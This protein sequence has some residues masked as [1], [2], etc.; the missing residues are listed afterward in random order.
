L[1]TA[2]IKLDPF[3]DRLLRWWDEHGRQDLPWQ[4]PRTPY[5]VWVSEI[6]LQQT[7]VATVIPYFERWMKRFPDLRTLAEAPLDDVLAHW[8]GL[9]Y[10]ARARNLHRAAAQCLEQHTGELPLNAEALSALPGIGL[11]TANAIISQST[12]R[13]AAVL[14]GN[15]RRSLARHL[16]LDGWTG[17]AAVQKTLW[18]EAEARLPEQRGADYT[19]AIM[20]L[21]AMVCTRSNPDCP[22]CPVSRDCR[23][24]NTGQV[25]KYPT[26]RPAIKVTRKSFCMLIIRDGQGRVLLVKRPPSGIWGGL[27]SLPMGETVGNIETELGLSD[28]RTRPLET[29]NHRLSHIHMSIHAAMATSIGA[30]HVKCSS[31]QSWLDPADHTSIGLPKPVSELLTRIKDG[32]IQ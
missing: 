2:E 29:I 20:D 12:D 23:A 10:Y 21:G 11:S 31:E 25:H 5:R 32:D 26:P 13:P 15:V 28:I 4:Q 8:A 18:A 9:G 3:S 22:T 14:D 27:W 19:Q 30:S 17:K 24:F 16:A 7:Q 6:M 1:N